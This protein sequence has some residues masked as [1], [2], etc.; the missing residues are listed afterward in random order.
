MVNAEGLIKMGVTVA[1]VTWA[2]TPLAAAAATRI[3]VNCILKDGVE[4][5]SECFQ[6]VYVRKLNCE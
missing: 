4:R 1:M 5:L 3:E 6:Q 2:A